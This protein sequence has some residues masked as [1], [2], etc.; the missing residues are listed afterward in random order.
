MKSNYFSMN[1]HEAVLPIAAFIYCN[2]QAVAGRQVG[3]FR[4]PV[5][6]LTI[7]YILSHYQYKLGSGDCA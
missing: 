1:I 6:V 2:R 4:A 7:H 3:N 5:F